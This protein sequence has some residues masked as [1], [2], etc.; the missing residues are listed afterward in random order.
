M[1]WQ[2]YV[3]PLAGQ[4]DLE[5]RRVASEIDDLGPGRTCQVHFAR[6]YLIDAELQRPEVERIA[7]EL[8]A[9]PV[10]EAFAM[11]DETPTGLVR[12]GIIANV[13]L[14]PGVMD[15]VAQSVAQAIRQL[16]LKV[17]EVHTFRR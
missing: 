8:L 17:N 14:K 16:G 10:I 15:P 5:G 12:P 11:N 13:L 6:G 4:P 2:V 1:L 9:D 3:F 7:R